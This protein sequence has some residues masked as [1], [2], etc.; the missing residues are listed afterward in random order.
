VHHGVLEAVVLRWLTARER[1]VLDTLLA[2][3]AEWTREWRRGWMAALVATLASLAAAQFLPQ[4]LPVV[5]GFGAWVV[6]AVGTPPAGGSWLG[7]SSAMAGQRACAICVLQPLGMAEAARVMGKANLIRLGAA[8]PHFILY[9]ALGGAL[10]ASSAATGAVWGGKAL[11]LLV[12]LIPATP[13]LKYSPHTND[14]NA[15]C[16]PSLA[17]LVVGLPWLLSVLALAISLFYWPAQ[18][19]AALPLIA[20]LAW[21]AWRAYRAACEKGAFDLMAS[22]AT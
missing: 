13:V 17:F 15:G 20:L 21:A 4:A 11:L 8:L 6:V 14:T 1:I 5:F 18:G 22:P 19:F 9:G 7:F 3:S 12:A 2:S 16:L 10:F